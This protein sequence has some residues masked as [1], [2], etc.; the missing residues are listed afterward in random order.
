MVVSGRQGILVTVVVEV[1]RGKVW[2]VS[3]DQSCTAEA[4]LE[5]AQADS[6]I[7]LLRQ[8]ASE[9]RGRGEYQERATGTTP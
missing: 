7:D 2:V 3:V 4:I 9:A 6:L 1:Y 8:A 5:P